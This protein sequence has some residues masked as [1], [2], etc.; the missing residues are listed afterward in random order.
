MRIGSNSLVVA[1]LV[2][3]PLVASPTCVSAE[4]M[5]PGMPITAGT[6]TSPP[7]AAIEGSSQTSLVTPTTPEAARA[8]AAGYADSMPKVRSWAVENDAWG[9]LGHPSDRDYTMGVPISESYRGT[10]NGLAWQW[11]RDGASLITSNLAHGQPA[12]ERDEGHWVWGNATYTPKDLRTSL[13]QK[14]DRPYASY[15]YAGAGYS[16]DLGLEAGERPSLQPADVLVSH[17]EVGLLGTQVSR[18]VQTA[19]HRVCCPDDLP[20]GWDNQVGNGGSPT[21]L[22]GLTWLHYR[23]FTPG[24]ASLPR[25]ALQTGLGA[26]VGYRVRV[27]GQGAIFFGATDADIAFARTSMPQPVQPPGLRA[28]AD[29]RGPAHSR[30]FGGYLALEVS[31]IAYNELMQGAWSGDN[32]LRLHWNE[33]EHGLVAATTGLDLSFV[34]LWACALWRGTTGHGF[35]C[36]EAPSF[37]WYLVQGWHSRDVRHG[38]EN[39]HFWGGIRFTYSL[40]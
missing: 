5:Q 23:P 25:V 31:G 26:E 2:L 12:S 30:G 20:R 19:I 14:S 7:S 22:Y 32:R 9:R 34:N 8:D 1:W 17:L 28:A 33:Y 13:P 10:P 24:L 4:G 16:S 15:M 36:D 6:T 38:T 27:F 35:D 40:P 21:F 37:H 11:L 3:I 18:E 39:S 29:P